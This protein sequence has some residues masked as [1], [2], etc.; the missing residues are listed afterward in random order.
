M[1]PMSEQ[2]SPAPASEIAHVLFL[3]LVG[4]SIL[5]MGQE[6]DLLHDL[7]QIVRGTNEFSRAQDDGRLIS[8]PTGD[9]VALV[10][11]GDPE[12]SVRCAL[13]LSRATRE[14]PNIR[15]RMGLHTGPVYRVADINANRNVAG[16]GI[17]FAQ[18]AMDCGDAGHILLSGVVAD[19]LIQLGGWADYLHDL[20]ESEIK[21]GV[22][23]HLFNLYGPEFGNPELPRRMRKE[24]RAAAVSVPHPKSSTEGSE[25]DKSRA[26]EV[27]QDLQDAGK[28]LEEAA[29]RMA[30]QLTLKLG[31]VALLYKRHAH[32]DEEVLSLLEQQLRTAGCK[33]FVDRHLTIGMEWAREIEHRVTNADAIVVLLSAASVQSEMLTYELEIAREAAQN[34]DGKPWLLPVRLNFDGPLPDTMEGILGGIQYATWGGPQDNK[35]LVSAIITSLKNPQKQHGRALKL[36]SVGGA[37]PLDSRFYIVRTTDDD[38]Y[39]AIDRNDT[40]VLIKGARQMGKTSLMARG[41][42]EARK[43]GYKV[44][45][46]DFQKLNASHLESVEKLF[47][48]LAGAIADQLDIESAAEDM[49]NPRRGPSMNFERF[50]RREI[51]EKLPCRLVWGIDEADRLFGYSFGTEVFGLIRSWHNERSLNPDGP[52]QKLTLAIAYATEAHMFISDMNQSP[53]NVGTRLVLADFTQEQVYQLN[54]RY[55]GP[56]KGRDELNRFYDL[57]GGQP[58]LTRRGLHEFATRN[59][60]FAEFENQAARDDGPFGDHLRRMLV[61]LAQDPALSET[62]RRVL[63]GK[64]SS[65]ADSFYRLRSSG[66]VAGESARDM[67][68]RCRLYQVYLMR[69]LA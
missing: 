37:V 53:F 11:F 45:L 43:A 27:M 40:I 58:Y 56:L 20:G 67:R 6:R 39:S 26:E 49:W 59:V 31:E 50:M 68:P 29:A 7:Q 54:C 65:S 52:W 62:M 25:T 48:T 42:Q 63:S 12:A 36:E 57:L 23:L 33:V 19:V 16:G 1:Q 3:D 41:L 47:L 34:R 51:L 28:P 14:K 35:A 66:I 18:R 5:P 30:P 55:G 17:N 4:Y 32:P 10:F 69:H 8:L 9:G 24:L 60:T 46:T 38:L 44:V 13:E 15:L 21:H 22:K 64:L 61:C 2:P